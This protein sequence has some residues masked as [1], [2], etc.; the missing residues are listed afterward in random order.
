MQKLGFERRGGVEGFLRALEEFH[1]YRAPG[2]V[3]GGFMV[4]LAVRQMRGHEMLDA[5][6][7]T[8]K[9][10]IDAV[11]LLTPCTAGN[12]WVRVIDSGRYALTLYDK[13][14]FEGVRVWVDPKKLAGFPEIER[15]FFRRASKKDLP[16]EVLNPKIVAAGEG[17]LSWR[18]VRVLTG[19]AG[20]RHA[21]EPRLC[22]DC[23]ESFRAEGPERCPGCRGSYCEVVE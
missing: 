13:V 17:I 7:E 3:I 8:S 1:G 12:G 23:G 4:D 22:S 2:V 5:V 16:L 11:Q 10:L 21:P 19:A 6:V 15:W 18:R 14:T 9:C 20:K